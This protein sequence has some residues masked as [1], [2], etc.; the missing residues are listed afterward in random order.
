MTIV[1]EIRNDPQQGAK[2]L[3][4]E[5]RA[6]LTTLARRICHDDGDAAELVNHTFAEVIANIDRYAEQSAFFGWMSKILVNLHAKEKR[7][8]SNQMLVFPGEVPECVDEDA[9]ERIYREV[10]ASLLRDAVSELPQEMRDAVVLR[11]FMDL[12]LARVAKI[13]SV[14]EGTV[15][16]RLHY[17]RLAL[18]AKLGAT[19]KKPGGKAI[20]LALLL[21]GLTALGAAITAAL[22]DS[23]TS[24]ASSRVSSSAEPPSSNLPQSP[25][26]VA[27]SP[28]RG[29]EGGATFSQG[30]PMNKTQTTRAAAMLA[31]ATVATSAALPATANTGLLYEPDSYAAQ[32]NLVL[33]LDGIRNAGALKAHDNAAASW[34]DLASSR[35]AAFREISSISSRSVPATSLADGTSGWTDDGYYFNGTSLAQMSSSLT[36]G[37]TY[38]IQVVCDVDTD[39][40]QTRFT[41]SAGVVSEG[42]L[43]WPGFVGSTDTDGKDYCNIY[44]NCGS[45]HQKVNAKMGN[46]NFDLYVTKAAWNNHYLTAWSSG[47][48]VSLFDG[49]AVGTKTSKNLLVGTHTLTFGA[50]YGSSTYGAWRRSLVGTIKAIRIYNKALTDDELEQNRTIDEI[51]FFGAIPVTNVVVAT[52]TEGLEGTEASG[53]YAI[54]E[55]GHTFSAPAQATLGGKIYDCT[56]Y[57]LETWNG[58]GWGEPVLHDGVLAV[59]LSDASAK[60][61]LT[62]Q[63]NEAEVVATDYTWMATPANAS[64]DGTSLNWN[65]GEAWADGNNAIFGASSE[66]TVTVGSERLV[67]DLTIDDVAYTFNGTGPLRVSGTITPVGAKDQK[68]NVP[69]ASGR[70]DGSLHFSATGVDWRSAYLNSANNQQTSTWLAGTVFL[71]AGSDGAFGPAPAVPTENIV[72]ESGNPLIYGNGTFAVHSNRIVKIKSGSALWTGSNSPFTWKSQIVAEADEDSD[73]SLDTYFKIRSNWGGLV[74][75]DPGEGRTNAFGRLFVDTRRLKLASGTTVV[76]G[77]ATS[78]E[79]SAI[80]YVKGNGSGTGFS[81]DRGYLLIDGGELSSPKMTGGDR[82]VDV[83]SYGQVVVTN[84]GKVV[85]PEGVQWL[86]GLGT[87]GKLTVAKDGSL[88][89]EQL[90]VSQS[91]A[92]QSEVHLD[93]GGLIAVHQ[94][95]MDNASTGLFAFNGGCLQATK[96]NRAFYAGSAANWTNVAFTVGE[97]GAGFDLSNGV[98]LWWGKQLRS[99]VGDGETD[100]GL[101]KRGSGILV[102]T[103][104]N[105]YNGPTVIE[106]GRIQARVDNAIPAGT[107]LRLGGGADARFT[108]STYDSENPRRDT[109]QAIGRVEGSGELDDMDASSVTGAIAPAADGIITFMTPCNLSGDYEVTVGATTNSLLVLKEA[110]QDI[111]G[112]R[113]KVMNPAALNSDADRDTYKILDAPKGYDGHFRLADDFLGNKWNVRYESGAAYLSPVRAFVIMVK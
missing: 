2:R 61:R 93:E 33:H 103:S 12:P 53:A 19:A 62:W 66:T 10:D 86:N 59:V 45:G 15:N 83:S 76:T 77:P 1:E 7:R 55:D 95:R 71:M 101:F 81:T 72:I 35:T 105:A 111:S 112:L 102:L 63:W 47:S 108:A 6:G 106:S 89:V 16:S 23:G 90:R 24:P 51:R 65:S 56:G 48:Q 28:Q 60:V 107:T 20:L 25:S 40:F 43:Q 49:D 88:A 67:N 36:L 34:A 8:I 30:E 78:T 22:P 70:D 14:P 32:E 69:L 52:A 99:G 91:G 79:E 9:T 41:Q 39:K 57:T 44:Y 92:A 13:L 21:C 82:Y 11:Y 38:T 109:A 4:S 42:N 37:N 46:T 84:G 54:A 5:Y 50:S 31:A 3:D 87:P 94:L 80:L 75:F 27:G 97:K 100:G 64:W 85:M 68:F 29:A 74:T 17:A 26:G 98:N 96:E 73:Y 113:V 18:T 58:S 104:A 110:N